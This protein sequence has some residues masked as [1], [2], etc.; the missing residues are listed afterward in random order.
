MSA[1]KKWWFSLLLGIAYLAVFHLFQIAG[2]N[3][4]IVSGLLATAL[5]LSGWLRAASRR[6]FCNRV[7]ALL[8]AVVILDLLLESLFVTSHDSRSFYL[9]ALAFAVVVGGYRSYELK[10]VSPDSPDARR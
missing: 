4:V 5:M 1:V 10:T 7:D 3:V 9:C 8:H 6:Y 2:R